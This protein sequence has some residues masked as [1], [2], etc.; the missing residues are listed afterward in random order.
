[1]TLLATALPDSAPLGRDL[2]AEVR[3]ERR[4]ADA[5]ERRILQIAVEYAHANPALPG[6]EEWQPAQLPVWTD[7]SSLDIDPADV[8][9]YRLPS[10]R[11]DA[12]AAFAAANGMTTVAGKALIRDALV[13]THRASGVWAAM[14]AGHIAVRVARKVAEKLLGQH[15]DVC[16]YV[17]D[18]LVERIKD[19]Q[20]VGPVV[21]EHLVDE[22]MLRLH[23]EERE[24]D[25]I[26]ALDK[27]HVTVD[28]DSINYTGVVQINAAADLAD[29]APFDEA[30]SA[31][32]EA[33]KDLP[34]YQDLSHDERRSVALA[35]LADP[36]RAQAILD[37]RADAKPTVKRELAATLNLTDGNLLGID[38]VVTDADLKA[39]LTQL[40]AQW[41]GRHD[42]ALTIKT[43]WHCGGRDG[44]CSACPAHI[45]CD[46]HGRH[47]L[48]GYVPSQRDREIVERANATCA[49]PY[50]RRKA[51][52]CDC[53]H[54]VAFDPE[55][56][57][58]GPT[59][60]KC[61]LAPLCRH[62]HR[63]KT[64]TGWRYWK[65]DLQTYLWID[66]HGLMYLR[67]RDGTRPLE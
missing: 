67:T 45:D 28:V 19:G 54:V 5:S 24:L 27:R 18:A 40:V 41:S 56:P 50:C 26:E 55:N 9:W 60:P 42:I 62:H 20:H 38:P 25:Q 30:L 46:N 14:Q 44:G 57:G 10:L 23:C 2:L 61:N 63:L 32:A 21:V 16:R 36:A 8:E 48:E 31:V 1:M 64:H 6:H 65:L 58:R 33:I 29:A 17:T 13:L 49:H 15:D 35:I 51:R 22:A 43:L 39:R 59:C 34:E 4:A 53:D 7:P 11:W 37:G 3:D 52:K 47:A 66:P 12:P